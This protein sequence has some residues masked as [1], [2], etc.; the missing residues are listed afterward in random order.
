M[1]RRQ[2]TKATKICADEA[3]M[4]VGLTSGII[5]KSVS[6]AWARTWKVKGLLALFAVASLAG[7]VRPH[8]VKKCANPSCAWPPPHPGVCVEV[9]K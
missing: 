9:C 5:R 8:S 7:C 6:E 4:A 3:M 2:E 1:T